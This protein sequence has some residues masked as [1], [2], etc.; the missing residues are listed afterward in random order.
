MN[1]DLLDPRVHNAI[2]L[3]KETHSPNNFKELEKVLE[4]VYHCKIVYDD[5]PLYNKGHLEISEAK[6]QTWFLIQFGDT[7]E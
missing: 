4:E 2:A 1:I 3:V 5:A 7:S 6:Y